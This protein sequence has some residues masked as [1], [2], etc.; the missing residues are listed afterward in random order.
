MRLDKI[1]SGK[2][3]KYDKSVKVFYFKYFCPEQL[4]VRQFKSVSKAKAAEKRREISNLQR[5]L[6]EA[7]QSSLTPFKIVHKLSRIS[8]CMEKN[9]KAGKL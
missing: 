1:N 2:R 6:P 4:R 8:T 7:P 3:S 5:T 9:T